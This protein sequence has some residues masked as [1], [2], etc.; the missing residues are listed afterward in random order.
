MP[1]LVLCATSDS[2]RHC[3]LLGVRDGPEHA[4]GSGRRPIAV[5]RLL[6]AAHRGV[7]LANSL[8]AI[9]GGASRR[10]GRESPAM[11]AYQRR[12]PSRMPGRGATR[13]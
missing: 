7:L 13:A 11:A 5:S 10:A 9:V 3:A 8:L 12:E 1:Y 2:T 6:L 4:T